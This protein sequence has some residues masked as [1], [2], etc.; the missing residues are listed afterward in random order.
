V[1]THEAREVRSRPNTV[2]ASS[3]ARPAQL[4]ALTTLR[5]VAA[6][7]VVLF[8]L[9]RYTTWMPAGLLAIG[10]VASV[11]WSGAAGV[12]FFFVLSGFI[13]THRYLGQPR[14]LRDHPHAFW[15]AR[16]A[17]VY[18]AYALSLVLGLVPFVAASQS[19][20][21]AVGLATLTLTQAWLPAGQFQ[22]WNGPG[23]SL[24][25]EAFFYALFPFVLV[26]FAQLNLR[27][28]RSA[29]AALAIIGVALPALYFALL[30]DGPD[31]TEYSPW[32]RV[33]MYNPAA[34]LHEFLLG[35][36]FCRLALLRRTRPHVSV[37]LPLAALGV[38]IGLIALRAQIPGV[39]VR[40][41]LLPPVFALLIAGLARLDRSL[42]RF[43]T[44]PFALALGEASFGVYIFHWPL[45][46]WTRGLWPGA[47]GALTCILFLGATL[48]LALWSFY[49]LEQPA[50]RWLRRSRPT[51]LDQATATG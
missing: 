9:T 42:P 43:V 26:R 8:H 48:S 24:S 5:F 20:G 41:G 39:E 30:P 28:V 31:W 40:S 23:W 18:P 14:S 34:H 12:P 51:T 7:W 32:M 36:A 11:L 17:R 4:K 6:T 27:Q 47:D 1:A 15:L 19:D 35:V 3:S 2:A 10:P 33:L 25:A 21:M 45:L 46:E 49:R 38:L 22:S 50:R 13:L 16:F 37:V 44:H 29:I